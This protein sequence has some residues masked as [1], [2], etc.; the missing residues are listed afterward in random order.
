MMNSV[1]SYSDGESFP[2]RSMP[3]GNKGTGD[4]ITAPDGTPIHATPV[5]QNEDSVHT[6]VH[7]NHH[8]VDYPGNKAQVY[9]ESTSAMNE[10]NCTFHRSP[11]NKKIGILSWP[12]GNLSNCG[13]ITK[14]L[15]DSSHFM[16]FV[17]NRRKHVQHLQL[18]ESDAIVKGVAES[19]RK[20]HGKSGTANGMNV[21]A[22]EFGKE[23]K[24]TLI[25]LSAS[26]NTTFPPKFIISPDADAGVRAKERIKAYVLNVEYADNDMDE[27][28]YD[29]SFDEDAEAIID[30]ADL[31]RSR[32][33]EDYHH[34]H[35]NFDGDGGSN[36]DFYHYQGEGSEYRG[37]RRCRSNNSHFQPPPPVLDVSS[38][39]TEYQRSAPLYGERR[40]RTRAPRHNYDDRIQG[41]QD[42][43]RHDGNGEARRQGIQ[44]RNQ[45]PP[46]AHRQGQRTSYMSRST[47]QIS[48]TANRSN[49]NV[50]Y[51]A[52]S[53]SQMNYQ[54]H[55]PE[56]YSNSGES[57]RDPSGLSTFSDSS[58]NSSS[59]RNE[60]G[61]FL[62]NRTFGD[63][64]SGRSSRVSSPRRNNGGGSVR[65]SE[66]GS[67]EQQIFGGGANQSGGTSVTATLS[68]EDV[69]SSEHSAHYSNFV[70][71]HDN[72]RTQ[73]S[74]S[75]DSDGSDGNNS[76]IPAVVD[77]GVT[78]V[79][80]DDLTISTTGGRGR[81]FPSRNSNSGSD[82]RSGNA[83]RVTAPG[84]GYDLR[85]RNM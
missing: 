18:D 12:K 11:Y 22:I 14:A 70:D 26:K 10:G 37:E 8:I 77:A 53:S 71:E 80:I 74:Y 1:D 21:F 32:R 33:V 82:S 35:G 30:S 85:S 15:T 72:A 31:S 9:M 27:L 81:L 61:V 62:A 44:G 69:N 7:L 23:I 34:G 19:A 83:T 36:G 65:G 20:R 24:S 56:A 42:R 78:D 13:K 57:P 52:A 43:R 46:S 68:N 79:E 59:R 16:S 2:S 54:G 5:A 49:V 58:R 67:R 6:Q 50:A 75:Y 55:T 41:I 3:P 63:A 29:G 66:T 17:Q 47:P 48:N 76:T 4:I 51:S 38:P 45:P 40:S 39:H 84:P 64:N 28:N 73:R 25:S 60:D